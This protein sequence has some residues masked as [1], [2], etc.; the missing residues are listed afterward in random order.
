MRTSLFALALPLLLAGCVSSPLPEPEAE[1]TDVTVEHILER[2]DEAAQ[3]SF[4]RLGHQP[5]VRLTQVKVSLSTTVTRTWTDDFDLVVISLDSSKER[6]QAQTVTVV[7]E[8]PTPAEPGQAS[9]FEDEGKPLLEPLVR[10]FDAA[11]LAARGARAALHKTHDG[12][13]PLEAKTIV[14]SVTFGIETTDDDGISLEFGSVDLSDEEIE[15]AK[16]QQK[17]EL[18]FE[19]AS[20]S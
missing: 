3:I 12:E 8:A 17:V 11:M 15:T 16:G 1:A 19:V 9:S 14:V 6:T 10:A 5:E 20:S 4:T 13:I 7:L 2:I 18:T